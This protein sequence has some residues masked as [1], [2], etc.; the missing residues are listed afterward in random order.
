MAEQ[1]TSDYPAQT[2]L[3]DAGAGRGALSSAFFNRWNAHSP[4]KQLKITAYEL[5]HVVLPEL[6]SALYRIE[7]NNVFIDV[8]EGDFVNIASEMVVL[9][10]G[11]RFT[12]AIL[13]PPYK[14][15]S[16]NSLHRA[17]L[18]AAGVETVNLYSGF[19]ALA[20][21]LLVEGGE[22]VAIIPRSFC[23]GPYYQ[24]F[25]NFIL[26]KSSIDFIHL[27]DSRTQAFKGDGVLQENVI[28]KITR[29]KKQGQV[30]ISTSTDD[31]FCDLREVTYDFER[32]VQPHDCNRF[33]HVPSSDCDDDILRN[34]SF[35]FLLS[36]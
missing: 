15:I 8:V 21:T 32:I 24:P 30:R 22:L 17:Y 2:K 12:H 9:N 36:E 10:R 4:K 1:F 29:G 3:L 13:N 25:R 11:P 33:I 35:G 5:D 16:S 31:S 27:F 19:V 14:K 26:S 6:V 28:I 34:G 23:N 7:S 20:L 18:R